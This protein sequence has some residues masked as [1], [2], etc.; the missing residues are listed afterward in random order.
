MSRKE[1]IFSDR[2]SVAFI[3]PR[4]EDECEWCRL[5]SDYLAVESLAPNG[6][7]SHM[8]CVATSEF[9]ELRSLL[10]RA[11]QATKPDAPALT[12]YH[13]EL[14]C[15]GTGHRL[16]VCID[17]ITDR[18]IRL[19][20]WD[21]ADD[22]DPQSLVDLDAAEARSIAEHLLKAASATEAAERP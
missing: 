2:F 22:L 10:E 8:F 12:S 14:G 9:E 19:S 7:W 6:G 15:L 13:A 3:G 16:T 18:T 1:P 4:D 20:V 21:T 17:L 5:R 11:S